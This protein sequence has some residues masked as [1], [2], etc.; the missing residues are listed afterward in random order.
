MVLERVIIE[1][2][3]ASVIFS[4]VLFCIL[5]IRHLRYW[6]AVGTEGGRT[7]GEESQRSA[8]DNERIGV[9]VPLPRMKIVNN[10]ECQDGTS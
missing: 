4:T 8:R 1:I 2:H 10:V 9:N 3:R 6:G 7:T 5:Q